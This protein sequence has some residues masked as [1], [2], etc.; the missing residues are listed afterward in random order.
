MMRD[1]WT[2]AGGAARD[3]ADRFAAPLLYLS[4]DEHLMFG[5]PVCLAVAPQTTFGALLEEVLPRVYGAHPDFARIDWKQ[6]QWLKSG[7]VWTPDPARSLH[8]NGLRHKDVLRLRT[9]GLG[10]LDGNAF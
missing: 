3:A 8:E 2:S 9:P 10:G 7:R 1:A 5:A 4:W 6:V